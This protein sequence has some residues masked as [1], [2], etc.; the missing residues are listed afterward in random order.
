MKST[1]RL[2]NRHS[3]QRG[4]AVFVVM[5][6]ILVVAS[7]GSWGIYSASLTSAGS[8]YQRSAAQAQS[9]AELGILA[10]TGY[11]SV[12]G[13][14]NANY[15]QAVISLANGSRDACLSV[16]AGQFCKSI[17]MADIDSTISAETATIGTAF[18]ILDQTNAA[19]SMGPFSPTS[20]PDQAL[21]GHFILEMTDPKHVLVPGTDVESGVYQRVTLT[22]YGMVRPYDAASLCEMEQS[23]SASQVGVRAH[24]IIGPLDP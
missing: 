23:A 9:T 13:F 5:M 15:R 2:H 7:L 11:F 8:G 10:G 6:T 22:S 12:P 19:G 24:V 17:Y 16:D 20:D 18:S 4:A 21:E 14:A 3:S 1:R